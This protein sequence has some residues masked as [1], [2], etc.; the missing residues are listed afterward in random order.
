MKHYRDRGFSMAKGG[1]A[2]PTESGA[3][4]PLGPAEIRALAG[5]LGIRPTKKLG[6]NFV[7]DPNTVRRI[8]RLAALRRD[9]VVLEIGPGL[10]SLTLALLPEPASVIAVEIDPVL[11][12][13]LPGT[14]AERAPGLAGRLRVIATDALRLRRANLPEVP[15]VLVANL[16]YNVG[17]PVLLHVLREFPGL[18]GGLVMIQAEVVDRLAARPGGRD[19]GAPSAKLAWYADARRVGAV[20]RAVF[21]PVPG[22]DSA[23]LGLHR[24]PE[25]VAEAPVDAVFAVVDAAFGQR[26]KSLR[27][28][29]AGWAGSAAVA[30]ARLRAAGVD[31]AARAE[32]LAIGDFARIADTPAAGPATRP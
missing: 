24:R 29:L 11:A 4:A 16:P 9:D 1:T 6:Q 25:P 2:V 31:P 32:R 27:A 15:T 20:P 14:V 10:G 22:V 13:A 8:A 21:W 7:H 18:R 30:E 5:R 19:Y 3:V 28:A 26:R 23:L 17:V 12:A